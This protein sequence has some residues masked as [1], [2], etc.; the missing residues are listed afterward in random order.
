MFLRIGWKVFG[1]GV[2]VVEFSRN[3]V[4]I[5]WNRAEYLKGMG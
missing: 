5:S 3:A 2:K 1:N 4:K